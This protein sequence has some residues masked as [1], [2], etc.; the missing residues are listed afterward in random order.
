MTSQVMVWE[1]CTR[2]LQSMEVVR[3]ETVVTLLGAVLL[4]LTP[5]F[6]IFP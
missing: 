1:R 6:Y 2:Y 3:P 4:A 5:Y